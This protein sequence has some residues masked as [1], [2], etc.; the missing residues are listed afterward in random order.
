MQLEI[1]R[2]SSNGYQKQA[3]HINSDLNFRKLY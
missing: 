1:L 2:I 3:A